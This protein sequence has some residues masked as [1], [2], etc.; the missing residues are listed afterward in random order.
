MHRFKFKGASVNDF[1]GAR[2]EAER[3]AAIAAEFARRKAEQYQIKLNRSATHIQRHWRGK[4]TRRDIVD[5]QIERREFFDLREKQMYLR[6]NP[7]YDFMAYWGVAPELPSDTRLE[8]VMKSYPKHMHGIIE[9]CINYKWKH[10]LK[11]QREKEEHFEKVGR[12]SDSEISR[13]N[14]VARSKRKAFQKA[15]KVLLKSMADLEAKKVLY[16][17]TRARSDAKKE[18]VKELADAAEATAHLAEANLEKKKEAEAELVEAESLVSDYTGPKGLK[19]LVNDRRKNGITLPFTVHMTQGSRLATVTYEPVPDREAEAAAA[20]A[21][22]E[23]AEKVAMEEAREADKK[24]KAA[25]KKGFSVGGNK[26]KAEDADANSKANEAMTV[27]KTMDRRDDNRSHQQ[28]LFAARK[29]AEEDK[30]A[31]AKLR[32]PVRDINGDMELDGEGR[33][34][35]ALGNSLEINPETGEAIIPEYVEPPPPDPKNT[36]PNYGEWVNELGEYDIV[37]IEGATFQVI[38]RD[39]FCLDLH[40]ATDVDKKEEKEKNEEDDEEEDSDAD[41]EEV[42][43]D[44]VIDEEDIDYQDT[45]HKKWDLEIME[46]HGSDDHICMDRPWVL[47]DMEFVSCSKVIPSIFYIKPLKEVGKK[48]ITS[49]FS[50]KLIQIG[51]INMHKVAALNMKIA[52]LFDEESDTGAWFRENAANQHRRKWAMLKSTRTITHF[53]FDFALRRSISKKIGKQFSAIRKLIKTWSNRAQA[54]AGD[55]SIELTYDF[56]ADN[57]AE[58]TVVHLFM[59]LGV[60][61]EVLLGKVELDLNCP[62]IVMREYICRNND[63][64]TILNTQYQGDNFQFFVIKENDEYDGKNG[65]S[66]EDWLCKREMENQTYTKDFCPFKID[67]KTM[68]GI[69]RCTLVLDAEVTAVDK[70]YRR[71]KHGEHI[72]E[73]GDPGYEE[74]LKE[75]EKK[76]KKKHSPNS[77]PTK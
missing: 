66:V 6:K 49:Y 61:G 70:I 5:Y 74:W 17:E 24:A 62:I 3:R 25:K 32:L 60:R 34:Y 23:E 15:E 14:Q 72:L 48:L 69:N 44:E 68:E 42:L 54:M 43:V 31:E 73:E 51:A 10:A 38:P 20:K 1:R 71:D 57:E 40:E 13:A 26:G 65:D 47:P 16:R 30:I 27:S 36:N 33:A 19:A 56:W 18:K 11:L 53:N 21:A 41:E 29:Q 77:S 4:T 76:G 8:R 9:E 28:K 64:R 7:V 2:D 35:D 46:G 39:E 50:Q 37:M 22:E 59:D 67:N 63:I 55:E 45:R 12:P 58:K 75:Q 52:H